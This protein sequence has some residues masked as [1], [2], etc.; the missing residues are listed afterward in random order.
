[1]CECLVAAIATAS[2]GLSVECNGSRRGRAEQTHVGYWVREE[3]GA[4]VRPT[5]AAT[6]MV[7][8]GE[9]QID[10]I[11]REGEEAPSRRY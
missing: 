2:T 10:R 6:L 9:S 4:A 5:A 7:M 1:M 11:G 8:H 3:E